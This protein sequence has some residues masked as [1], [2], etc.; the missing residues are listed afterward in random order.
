[1]TGEMAIGDEACDARL[2]RNGVVPVEA[3][4]G[5]GQGFDR[6]VGS[7][8]E[9][10]PQSGE[11]AFREGPDVKY[12]IGI[13][14]R[15][16][17]L[18]RASLVA[19]L[20]VVIVFDDDRSALPCKGDE[21]AP[22]FGAHCHSQRELVGRTDADDI[23]VGRN[24]IDRDSLLIDTNRNDV[25]A[26][27]CE[28]DPHQRVTGILERDDRFA[29]SDEDPR[30]KVE[31][32]LRACRHQHIVRRTYDGS[33]Q[34]NML[35][36]RIAKSKVAAVSLRALEAW[37]LDL[38]KPQL[39]AAHPAEKIERKQPAV[40]ESGPEIDRRAVVSNAVRSGLVAPEA[41]R[42]DRLGLQPEIVEAGIDRPTGSGISTS[43]LS[44]SGSATNVP[45]PCRP[46]T[47]PSP[48][49]RS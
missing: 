38:E 44:G 39:P 26:G 18:E 49:R 15:S 41:D 48:R 14:G 12:D 8:D 21:R 17:G 32:L 30:K 4:L 3:V 25:R 13:V 20:A 43:R 16:K 27:R 9:T 33:C 6:P 23:G 45:D 31:R 5:R 42:L 19:E 1:M 11:H 36:D 28:R 24:R 2:D 22:P 47:R 10:E 7:N 40:D 29:R 34:R 35:R 46:T 37:R